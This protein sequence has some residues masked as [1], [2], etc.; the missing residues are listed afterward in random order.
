MRIVAREESEPV[1]EDVLRC[2]WFDRLFSEEDLC[3]DQGHKIRIVSPGW[4]NKTAGPDF[5]GAQI[6]FD[7][8]L[9]SGDVEIHVDHGA[10]KQHGH[11]MDKRYDKV[12]LI[13]VLKDVPPAAAPYTTQ[14]NPV[15]NLLLTR[16][17][18]DDIRRISE[19]LN[20]EDY[21]H[22]A[23]AVV[24]QCSALLDAFGSDRVEHLLGLA[25]DWRLLFKARLLR[26]R[27]ERVGVAQ[28]TYEAVMTACGYS[29]FKQPFR[30]I[31][32]QLPYDRARQL[33][34]QDPLLLET[35]FLV[36]GDL[37]PESV[38]ENTP[39]AAH[40]SR[41]DTLRKRH[42]AGLRP[43]SLKWQ[44]VAVRPTNYPAR[45]LSG[46]ARMIART[47]TDGLAESLQQIWAENVTATER[48]KLF[49]ALFPRALGFWADHCSWSGKTLPRPAAPLGASRI[50]AIIGNVFV[51]FGLAVARMKRDRVFEEKVS[52]FFTTL[53]KETDNH[54]LRT[55]L[56]RLF[57]GKEPPKLTFRLQ[58]GL[59]QMYMDWCEP[60][61][62]CRNCSVLAGLATKDE[63]RR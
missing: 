28:A 32:E 46:A 2:V 15:P 20:V 29:A 14:G 38:A 12:I 53:P 58:Q 51:P 16:F 61:P 33:A 43:L 24:G 3:T 37:M 55:M 11:H 50:H 35:A 41:I 45:R 62:S 10:W 31:A 21:P 48:R 63:D 49:A 44:L 42:L 1:H 30:L 52:E 40:Y 36:L 56:I 23:P 27:M 4:W 17:L 47:A 8:K 7:G 57:P 59:M 6:E 22:A 39:A 60:N 9:R 19:N 54:V 34:R 26:E 5:K 25:G 13:V 18:K